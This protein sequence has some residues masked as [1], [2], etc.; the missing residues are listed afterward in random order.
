MVRSTS[1]A[2]SGQSESKYAVDTDWAGRVI[3]FVIR[4][5]HY[6]LS[7][8]FANSA[9][10][11]VDIQAFVYEFRLGQIW[12]IFMR[13]NESLF[14]FLTGLYLFPSA[15]V[16]SKEDASFLLGVKFARIAV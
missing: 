2:Q 1:V 11:P 9:K 10:G 4:L 16:G 8:N 15:R 5:S 14:A 3:N 13:V 7:A 6:G 12:Q